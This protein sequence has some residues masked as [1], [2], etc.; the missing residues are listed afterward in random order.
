MAG[1][2]CEVAF[3]RRPVSNV[4][5]TS[6]IFR[7]QV[8][9]TKF[10]LN[11]LLNFLNNHFNGGDKETKYSYTGDFPTHEHRGSY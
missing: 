4:G 3:R 7:S 6:I 10:D 5:E 2:M 9:S 1:E 8:I 11:K